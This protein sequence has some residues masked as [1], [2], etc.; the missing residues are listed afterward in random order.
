MLA[1]QPIPTYDDNHV[2]LK[3]SRKGDTLTVRD[4]KNGIQIIG[5]PGMG[6]TNG[7]GRALAMSFLKKKIWWSS[8]V[9]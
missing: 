8:H 2:L 9:C 5:M 1:K 4:A 3:L 7:S 6:K